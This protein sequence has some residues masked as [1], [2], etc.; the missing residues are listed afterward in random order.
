M[1]VSS[2]PQVHLQV[3]TIFL[4]G[5]LTEVDKHKGQSLENEKLPSLSSRK[6]MGQYPG[7]VV[8]VSS[9]VGAT[10]LIAVV[11]GA[12]FIIRKKRY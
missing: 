10:F 4:D 1:L 7:N 12:A 9:I 5:A 11:T 6:K 3:I 8:I 2:H